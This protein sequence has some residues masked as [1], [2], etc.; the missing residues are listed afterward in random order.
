MQHL[1]M[2]FF[3]CRTIKL[4]FRFVSLEQP[5]LFKVSCMVS[6]LDSLRIESIIKMSI[7]T[8]KQINKK[9][10]KKM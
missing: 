9:K 10:N 6:S 5:F 8:V 3:Y 1:K 7:K 4:I 2:F